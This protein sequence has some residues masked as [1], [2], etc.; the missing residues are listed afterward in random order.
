LSFVTPNTHDKWWYTMKEV[1][2]VKEPM[3][4]ADN[5]TYTTAEEWFNDPANRRV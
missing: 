1:I 4:T 5:K 3:L 2:D